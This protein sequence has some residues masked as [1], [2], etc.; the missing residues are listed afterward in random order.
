M[1]KERGSVVIIISF[2]IVVFITILGFIVNVG[3][4]SATKN[5]YENAAEAAAMAGAARLCD[6]DAIDVAKQ[7]AQ[8]NG[9]DPDHVTVHLGFYDVENERFYPKSSIPEGEYIN[10]V[11]VSIQST[12]NTILGSF[13]GK[14]QTQVGAVAVAYLV[15][16]GML[17]LGED[18]EGGITFSGF[19]DEGL[20]IKGGDILS[21]S[22]ITFSFTPDI[23]ENVKVMAVGNIN[24]YENGI[25]PV[26]PLKIKPVTSFINEIYK[27]YIGTAKMKVITQADFPTQNGVIIT[28]YDGNEYSYKTALGGHPIFAPHL[29]DHGGKIYYFKDLTSDLYIYNP[30]TALSSSDPKITNLT[31][32]IEGKSIYWWGFNQ[33][34]TTDWGGKN[35]EQVNIITSKSIL[36]GGRQGFL[37]F[38]DGFFDPKG[39]VL[40]AGQDIRVTSSLGGH[41]SYSRTLRM[42]AEGKI[43]IEGPGS[44]FPQP[45]TFDFNFGPPCPPCIIKLAP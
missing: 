29:G 21:N 43:N 7:I 32:V 28:D 15:R 14:E 17:A 5:I 2:F 13:L 3:Y 41:N 39:V 40:W 24:G 1:N 30:S 31:L 16:Y 23:D 20:K 44:W 27:E 36:F 22:D 6:G 9:V 8:E 18:S 34:K 4:L 19:E 25:S 12:E 33:F 11:K 26:E 45:T 42:I 38:T 10:A 35:D 37:K